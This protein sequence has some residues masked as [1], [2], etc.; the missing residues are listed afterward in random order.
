[1][2][3]VKFMRRTKPPLSE[4]QMTALMHVAHRPHG[5]QDDFDIGCHRRGSRAQFNILNALRRERVVRR[6]T[7]R[8]RRRRLIEKRR[9][10]FLRVVR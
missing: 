7:T 4:A 5:A 3:E 9:G 8:R 10:P 1:M 6:K 2:T